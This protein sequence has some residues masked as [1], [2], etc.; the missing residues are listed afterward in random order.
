[1]IRERQLNQVNIVPGGVS[2]IEISKDAVYHQMQLTLAGVVQI[3]YLTG[4]S[5]TRF[6]QGFP[7]N[8][9]SNLRLIRN[10]SDVVWQGSGKQ[11]AK[12][13]L[14]LNDHYPF[15]RLWGGTTSATAQTLLTQ[16]VNGITVPSNSEGI[17]ANVA[18]FTD[19][20]MASSTTFVNFRCM[21]E[22]W[23]QLGVDDQFFTTLV[24]AR[25]LASFV[26]EISWAP[27]NQVIVAGTNGTPSLASGTC[28]VQ[29]YDQDNVALGQPFGT[30]KRS[31]NGYSTFAFNSNQNQALLSRGNFY[32]GVVFETL[33]FRSGGL[34]T[35]PEP[36]NDIISQITNRINSNYYL[37]DV[38][39][40]N[41]QA[42]N[43]NDSKISSSPFDAW[44]GGPLGWAAIL[45]SSVG[46]TIKELVPTYTMDQFDLLLTT[47]AGTEQGAV[48]G[49]P[50]INVFSQ[51][52][53][54]GRSVAPNMPQG[55]F[56]GSQRA[57]SAKPGA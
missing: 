41:L 19:T 52:V 21:L 31:S 40:N 54:P 45:Y 3:A 55:S 17:G 5:N 20:A 9:I 24:D 23:L 53:I 15:A 25:P 42:K 30:F 18:T 8:L 51:E 35:I 49:N 4:P 33:A 39:F 14:Y 1:M 11:L 26:L 43:R 44:S 16:T 50:V 22:L 57:T 34:I 12:E 13:S 28:V 10:G 48:T 2:T 38:G 46:D 7:F 47:G 36:G 29:S 56:A 6:A 27:L 37:R 32:F